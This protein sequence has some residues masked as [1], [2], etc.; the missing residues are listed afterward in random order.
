MSSRAAG[1]SIS[2]AAQ[3]WDFASA[4]RAAEAIRARRVSS[5]ELTQHVFE[6]ID[7]FNPVINAFAYTLRESA[8]AQAKKADEALAR[9]ESLGAFH[10]VPVSVKESFAVEGHP[11]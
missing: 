1:P 11:A 3:E 5:I 9:G 7:R 10:G 2:G 4:L 8:L 6:R